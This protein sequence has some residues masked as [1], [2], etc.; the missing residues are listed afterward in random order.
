MIKLKVIDKTTY[1]KHL[2]II[3]IAGVS[4]LLFLSLSISALLIYVIGDLPGSNFKLNLAGVVIA[5]GLCIAGLYAN[6]E[7]PFIH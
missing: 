4:L 6:R 3:S 2:K 7:H 5:T 1:R